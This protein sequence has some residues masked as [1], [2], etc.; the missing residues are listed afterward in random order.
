V[1]AYD[2]GVGPRGDCEKARG[3]DDESFRVASDIPDCA[4]F[5]A[6]RR[7]RDSVENTN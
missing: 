4:T 2:E 1:E 7:V 3:G 5:T 6:R